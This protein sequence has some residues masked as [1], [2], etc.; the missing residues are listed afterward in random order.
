MLFLTE[1]RRVGLDGTSLL[2]DKP[3]RGSPGLLRKNAGLY[4]RSLRY[5]RYL[6][7]TRVNLPG[8]GRGEIIL[9]YLWNYRS[10]T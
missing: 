8:E 3:N 10:Q 4:D 1:P 7:E 5:A 2:L 9:I 6:P